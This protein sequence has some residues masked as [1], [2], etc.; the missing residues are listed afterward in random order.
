MS[1]PK[2]RGRRPAGEETRDALLAAAR[3]L[4]A[5]NGY[6]NTTVRA[7]GG[8]AG[9]DPAMV[10]HWFGGKAELFAA[11][12]LDLPFGPEDLLARVVEGDEADLPERVVRTFVAIWDSGNL[13]ALLRNVAAQPQAAEVLR[14][15]MMHR[16]L[17]PVLET[18]APYEPAH[19]AAM[20]GNLCV[21]QLIGLGMARYVLRFEPIASA[22][23][24]TLAALV[25]PTIRRYL[26]EDIGM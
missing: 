20:R 25:G 13:T 22:D 9:V 3:E 14:D 18:V 17:A 10:N 16:V 6:E 12:V 5:E 4:F 26:T 19:R 1:T 24:D 2:R 15:L 7:L 11:A 21:S 8:R 23:V